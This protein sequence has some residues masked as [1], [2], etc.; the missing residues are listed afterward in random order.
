VSSLVHYV[1]PMMFLLVLIWKYAKNRAVF[2]IVPLITANEISTS[3]SEVIR[4]IVN[5]IFEIAT[6]VLTALGVA[7]ILVGLLL[8]LGLRQEFLGWRL[9]VAGLLTLVFVFFVAPFLFQ[10]I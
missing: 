8:A 9:I 1:L 3:I 10:F 2:T 5:Q 4:K 6:P 7:Q